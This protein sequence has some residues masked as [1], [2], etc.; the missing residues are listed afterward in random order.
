VLCSERPFRWQCAAEGLHAISNSGYPEQVFPGDEIN[1]LCGITATL[2]RAD[3]TPRLPSGAPVPT[4]SA[5]TA[6]WIR[7]ENMLNPQARKHR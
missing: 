4:C 1:A 6:E 3:Y 5:C 7:R 2:T